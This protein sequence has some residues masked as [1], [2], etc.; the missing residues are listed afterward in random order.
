[1]SNGYDENYQ[2]YY[3]T[4]WTIYAYKD[5]AYKKVAQIPSSALILS[6]DEVAYSTEQ[7][8]DGDHPYASQLSSYGT[9]YDALNTDEYK[10]LP[11]YIT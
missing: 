10:N 3:A 1:M 8:K 5:N 6:Y 2:G 11:A 7:S 4:E 9:A